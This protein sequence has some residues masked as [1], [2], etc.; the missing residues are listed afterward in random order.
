MKLKKLSS[1]KSKAQAMVEFAI[2]LPLL[3]M[4]LYGILEAG[5]LLFMYSTVVTAS[6]Q[7]VRYGSATGTGNGTG[8]PNERRYEDCDGIRAAAS[9]VGYI[10]A[11]DTITIAYDDGPTGTITPP[12]PFCANPAL[13]DNTPSPAD[14]P[15]TDNLSRILVTVEKEFVPLVPQIVP[16]LT[17]TISARSARTVIVGVTIAVTAV[18]QANSTVTTIFHEENPPTS[19]VGQPVSVTVTVTGGSTSPTGTVNITGANTNCTITLSNGTG[20]CNVVFTS[21]GTKLLE[22]FYGGDST[23]LPSS[24]SSG[25]PG[26]GEEHYVRSSTVTTI[27][28]HTPDPSKV[29]DPVVITVSVTSSGLPIPDGAVVNV[30]GDA[31]CTITLT[32]GT[33]NCTVTFASEGEKTITAAYLGDADHS[34]SSSTTTHDALLDRTTITRF[35]GH[36]PDPSDINQTVT[37]SVRVV[38]LTTPTGTVTISGADTNCTITLSSGTGSCAVIFTSVGAKTITATYAGDATHDPS[39]RSTGHTVNL[40][41]TTTTITAHTPDPSTV[42][43]SVSVTV[44][45]TGG[46]ATP[47]GTVTISG[48]D[49][50]CTITLPATSCNVVFS[51]SGTKTLAAVYSGDASHASSNNTATH[52]VSA[53]VASPVPSCNAVARGAITTSGNTM[54]MTI[55]NPYVFPLTTGPGTVTWNDDKGHQTGS[56][57]TLRLQSI[58]I[59]TTTIWTGNS[60]NV[61]TI[62][63]T[64]PAIIPSGPNTTVTITFTFHQSYDNFDGTE[65]IYINLTTP[66]C[67][68]DPI[69]S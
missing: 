39:S 9:K 24:D 62:P 17:R 8:N 49:A 69:Q 50:P 66:G 6:R 21:G 41:A 20:S 51:S 36:S 30:T 19:D 64:T 2:A 1:K 57:K 15:R 23:Y 4:L 48:A 54:T 32:S 58:V 34:G 53:P 28:S 46:S 47:T 56:D 61:S 26:A 3:L 31:T 65:N 18:P 5:R 22:A 27:T 63:W 7:A 68:G 59:G 10:G 12:I 13:T 16:F 37:V 11:F 14:F 29:G 35:T 44:T 60:S 40:P 45:V 42:G 67:E 43:Q 38:G 52:V 55:T 33:G 25:D